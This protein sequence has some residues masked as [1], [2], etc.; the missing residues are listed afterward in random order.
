MRR[1]RFN[2]R[3]APESACARVLPCEAPTRVPHQASRTRVGSPGLNRNHRGG[4]RRHLVETH[5]SA[6]ERPSELRGGRGLHRRNRRLRR[7]HHGPHR[8]ARARL[9]D[10]PQQLDHSAGEGKN[11]VGRR[12]SSPG[13]CAATLSRWTFVSIST[14]TTSVGCGE[15]TRSPCLAGLTRET[16]ISCGA[17]FS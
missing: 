16:A 17:P 1:S 15:T 14:G 11:S 4:K 2:E 7:V 13:T 9:G 6:L 5:G 12:H 8:R 3:F 10:V